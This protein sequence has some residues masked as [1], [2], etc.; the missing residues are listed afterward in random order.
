MRNGLALHILT[1][2]EVHNIMYLHGKMFA[3]RV[4]TWKIIL[5][6]IHHRGAVVDIR[7]AHGKSPGYH[8][9][10]WQGSLHVVN[11]Q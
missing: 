7:H 3:Y 2:E 11:Q 10:T 9:P 4:A 8:V 1:W 5:D 6:I